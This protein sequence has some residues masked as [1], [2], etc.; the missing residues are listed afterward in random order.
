MIRSDCHSHLLSNVC[1]WATGGVFFL[2]CNGESDVYKN[3]ITLDV[4]KREKILPRSLSSSSV[5]TPS[6]QWDGPHSSTGSL[7]GGKEREKKRCTTV[8]QSTVS[9]HWVAGVNQSQSLSLLCQ[10]M[11]TT[12]TKKMFPQMIGVWSWGRLLSNL[13][14]SCQLLMTWQ[15]LSHFTFWIGK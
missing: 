10:T 5:C 9:G 7:L 11:W 3:N 14:L 8:S 1:A 13:N 12:I 15:L 2:N 4:S 6:T